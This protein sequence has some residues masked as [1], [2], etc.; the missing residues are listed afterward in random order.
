[1]LIA[2]A[3]CELEARGL[4]VHYETLALSERAT[5]VINVQHQVN[6]DVLDLR[7]Y[8]DEVDDL[9]LIEMAHQLRANQSTNYTLLILSGCCNFTC[10]GLRSL[11][12][13]VGKAMRQLDCSCTDLSI[14]MLQVLATGIEHLDEVNFSSCQQLSSEDDALGWISGLMGPQSSRTR[15]RRLLSLDISSCNNVRDQGISHIVRGCKLLHVL[16][17]KRCHQLTNATLRRIGKHGVHLRTLDL[18]GCYAMSSAGLLEMVQGTTLLQS[19]NLEGCLR[20]REEILASVTKACPALQTFNLTGCHE[21][22]DAGINTLAERLIFARKAHSYRGLEPYV[23]GLLIKYSIQEQTIRSS[24]TLRLQAFYRGYIGRCVANS[25]SKL[26]EQVSASYKI[27][28]FYTCWRI[29][30]A[31]DLRV[32]QRKLF[33]RSAVR[34]QRLITGVPGRA[35]I[36]DSQ[37]E[38]QRLVLKAISAVKIQAAFRG[39]WTRRHFMFVRKYLERFRL[40]QNFLLRE[41][42]ADRLQKFIRARCGISHFES[43]MAL[44]QSRRMAQ[45]DA[46]VKLQRL[47]RAFATRRGY[48]QLLMAIAKQQEENLR[49][50]QIAVNVQSKWRGYRGRQYDLSLRRARA[51]S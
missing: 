24:A 51:N 26:L 5:S 22:T 1:M 23:D 19:L 44:N 32:K 29:R 15:C 45:C 18:S 35:S 49:L 30:R 27:W 33:N 7:P 4:E 3:Q 13:A 50:N 38:E 36:T 25:K 10:V 40:E 9:L 48:R 8:A 6:P 11:V 17:L 42:A 12:H 28:R 47:Y 34:I 31:L 21:I 46:V 43:L 39:F 20:M 37:V 41:R 14:P 16:S 2:N